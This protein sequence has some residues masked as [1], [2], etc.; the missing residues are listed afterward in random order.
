MVKYFSW[1]ISLSWRE[2]EQI[3]LNPFYKEEKLK[4]KAW[5]NSW[6]D[7]KKK[8]ITKG[9]KADNAYHTF[10]RCNKQ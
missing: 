3:N 6:K 7:L 9:L 10:P 2:I 8:E 1:R 4:L 5:I